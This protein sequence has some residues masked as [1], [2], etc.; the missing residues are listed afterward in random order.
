MSNYQIKLKEARRKTCKIRICSKQT[1]ELTVPIG[2]SQLQIEQVLN[3]N[4]QRI[5]KMLQ[6]FDL[7]NLPQAYKDGSSIMY[8]GEP[9]ILQFVAGV[10]YA[11]KLDKKLLINAK[12]QARPEEVLKSFYKARALLLR[13]RCLELAQ[14]HSFQP[15]KISLRWVISR[16]GSC[17]IL[18]NISLNVKLIMALPEIADYVIIHELAH[19]KHH[20]H[21]AEF[22]SLVQQLM[23]EYAMH[24]TWLKK[25]GNT[26]N[27]LR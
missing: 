6:Q 18:G 5:E 19:L 20:N 1:V 16:W 23:P 7:I 10:P 15:N 27:S 2:T 9:L 12:Y 26:L 11:W 4:Q 13:F 3:R 25:Y 21:S 22:W 8:L 14:K 24:R 17:S